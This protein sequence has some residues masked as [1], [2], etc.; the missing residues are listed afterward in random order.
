MTKSPIT[1]FDCSKMETNLSTKETAFIAL[2][3]ILIITVFVLFYRNKPR[4]VQGFATIQE[5]EEEMKKQLQLLGPDFKSNFPSDTELKAKV[6]NVM[7]HTEIIKRYRASANGMLGPI[8][9]TVKKDVA[10]KNIELEKLDEYVRS[11]N[12]YAQR[13]FMNRINLR[14]I[15]TVKSHNNGLELS[16]HKLRD[17]PVNDYQIRVNNGCLKVPFTND[18]AVV[19]CNNNDPEQ[20]FSLENVFNEPGYRAKMDAAYPQMD[21]LGDV[22]YPFSILRAKSNGNCVKNFHGN[23]SVEPCREYEGQRWGTS[24][25]QGGLCPN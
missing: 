19:A 24:D 8:E 21:N 16:V 15:R 3:I 14:D 4:V 13:D 5:I 2:F 25:K 7:P 11:L 20:V 22:R 1:F 23:L 12:E 9:E 17:G 18:A 6:D 10:D